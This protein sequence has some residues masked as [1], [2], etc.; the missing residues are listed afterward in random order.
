MA[1]IDVGGTFTD[2]VL[3]ARGAD[4]G[5]VRFAKV[6]TTLP[7]QADG[8][9]A[10]IDAA[11]V[12]PAELDLVIHG[13]TA[14]TNALL[15]RK[16]AKVGLITTRGF[17]DTLELGR[18]TRPKPYGLFGTF[19]PLMP[20]ER[21]HRGRRAHGRAGRDR[22]R[23]STRRRSRRR[24]GR[25]SRPAARASSS[26]SCTPTPT[27]PTSC[28]PARSS[29]AIW[30]N[31]YVTLGHRLLSEYREYERGTTASVNAAVQPILDR[32]IGRLQ[33]D[34]QA[35]GLSRATCS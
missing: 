30:P 33:G 10:A 3:Y 32:Y 21:R 2:L 23:R 15:E 6:P 1:G 28:A 31:D 17:R 19:E 29:Q 16:I 24:R 4:G 9:L 5:E 14:T 27:R 34:L 18:R 13:T 7:N 12:A 11:G 35:R 20:R 8:V 25:C 26:I 22:R